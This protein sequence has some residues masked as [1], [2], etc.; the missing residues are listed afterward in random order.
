MISHRYDKI[1]HIV[2]DEAD[3]VANAEI[4]LTRQGYA[5]HSFSSSIEAL[6]D[7]N[8]CR[9]NVAMLL[10]DVRMPRYGGFEL[11]RRIREII[12]DVPIIFMTAFEI[13]QTEFQKMFPSL[14]INAFLQK[15]FRVNELL[16]LVER[17][18][19]SGVK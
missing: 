14:E 9:G 10:T 16:E 12:P 4:A 1:I 3:I 2:D 11:A 17:F 15:P 7:I 8:K 6:D 19:Q 5:V 13:N 18:V